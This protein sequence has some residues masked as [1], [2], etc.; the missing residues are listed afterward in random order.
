M[1]YAI[2]I[3]RHYLPT[4]KF[5]FFIDHQALLYLVNKPCLI[6]HITRWML[7]LLEFD[8]TFTIRKGT[9]HVLA[10]HMSW[11]PNGE[12]TTRVDDNLLDASLFLIDIVHGWV[13]E[14]CHYLAN[15]LLIV[16]PLDKATVQILILSIVPY[17]LITSRLYKTGKDG[18]V[19]RC[20]REDS[21]HLGIAR[22]HFS[23]KTIAR[24]VLKFGLWWPTLFGNAIEFKKRC[25]PCKRTTKPQKWDRMPLTRNLAS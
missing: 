25:D 24:K 8:F 21:T 22:G 12:A 15:G 11:I 7:I 9:T 16:I 3:F 20:A 4:N 14:I 1:L 2:K 19:R 13:D 23:T 5:V 6:G 18:I 10:N 17:Q